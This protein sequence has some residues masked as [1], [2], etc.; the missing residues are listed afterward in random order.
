M[1]TGTGVGGKSTKRSGSAS[2]LQSNE[3]VPTE[4]ESA[5]EDAGP[6][7]STTTCST[8]FEITRRYDLDLWRRVS[9][10]CGGD[11]FVSTSR[12][13]PPVSHSGSAVVSPNRSA[14]PMEEAL[15]PPTHVHVVVVAAR[16]LRGADWTGF[17]D[18]FVEVSACGANAK[19]RYRT[20]V[21]T[22]TLNPTWTT[23]NERFLVGC[24]DADENVTASASSTPANAL[25]RK[26][27]GIALSVFDRDWGTSS[28]F[29]GGAVIDPTQIP[30]G[31]KWVELTLELQSE[32]P[33]FAK[34]SGSSGKKNRPNYFGSKYA[35]K[36][37]STHNDSPQN[38]G[39]ITVRISAAD[40]LSWD[41]RSDTGAVL[42]RDLTHHFKPGK[43]GA[44]KAKTAAAGYRALRREANS[45][46]TA[47]ANSVD[48]KTKLNPNRD[49][50][51]VP[52]VRNGTGHTTVAT[53]SSSSTVMRASPSSTTRS[54]LT[55]HVHVCVVAGKHL[56]A[57][58]VGR[59]T[60]AFVKLSLDNGLP[61]EFGK[62]ETIKRSLDPVWGRGAGETFTVP[63]RPGACE[64]VLDVYDADF[65]KRNQLVS[66]GVVPLFCLPANGSWSVDITVP[67]FPPLQTLSVGKDRLDGESKGFLV[68]RVGTCCVSQIPPTVCPYK[69]DTLFYL[70]QPRAHPRPEFWTPAMKVYRILFQLQRRRVQQPRQSQT[71]PLRYLKYAIRHQTFLPQSCGVSG[72]TPRI[73]PP[74]R[75]GAT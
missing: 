10:M 71:S 74:P 27:R 63:R 41:V 31:G 39:T 57:S 70:S 64:V 47:Q 11:E 34:P 9:S 22:Q 30:R 37:A 62:T 5:A 25:H 33:E 6:S 36:N 38:L 28:Q 61:S 69:A 17:S 14:L 43:F 68:V 21:A 72:R 40:D 52:G 24:D 45:V 44:T 49:S 18:P 15:P 50:N 56:S 1:G 67:L 16:G 51:P 75:Q 3:I 60:D 58:D 12:P 7:V 8:P 53:S 42:F 13:V 65:A 29:L 32:L 55:R 59:S 48:S 66:T 23:R 19:R 73:P 35:I 2:R 26:F 46:E 20:S 4:S 54:K